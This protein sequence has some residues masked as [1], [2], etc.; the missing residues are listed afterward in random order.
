MKV[1]ADQEQD[2]VGG[3]NGGPAGG[4]IAAAAFAAEKAGRTPRVADGGV[5]FVVGFAGAV[6]DVDESDA[7]DLGELEK[8]NGSGDQADFSLADPGLPFLIV[9]G[10]VLGGERGLVLAVV[11]D[12]FVEVED[13]GRGE[14]FK[15][16]WLFGGRGPVGVGESRFE[17]LG[18]TA[19]GLL[20]QGG[21]FD[22][23]T[24]PGDGEILL[25]ERGRAKRTR[26]AF[27]GS[28]YTLTLEVLFA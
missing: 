16:L 6:G 27:T 8:L 14:F 20:R 22:A 1:V 24:D 26:T 9:K 25:G 28:I 18:G 4:F 5:V 23:R 11:E 3:R 19:I 7:A 13:D 21:V 10:D 2:T 15:A 17:G 12:G